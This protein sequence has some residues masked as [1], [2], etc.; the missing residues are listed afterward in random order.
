M[1]LGRF[2]V[3]GLGLRPVIACQAEEVHR[4]LVCDCMP[5]FH[6]VNA[7]PFTLPPQPTKKSIPR[8]LPY[9]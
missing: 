6:L 1:H 3:G 5:G 9:P 4:P 7:E 8:L 2:L